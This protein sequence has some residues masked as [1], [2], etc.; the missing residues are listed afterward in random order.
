MTGRQ[1]GTSVVEVIVAMTLV[2]VIV[3]ALGGLT[4]TTARQMV[5]NTDVTT[6]QAASL[7]AVNRFTTI[8]FA[9]LGTA[10]GCDTVGSVNNGFQRCVTVATRGNS[11]A[12]EVRTMALQRFRVAGSTVHLTRVA[13]PAAN[14]LCLQC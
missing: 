12:V 1:Q 6:L 2:S 9:M 7:Q 3:T 8:P 11:A 5:T 4:F 14:P 10:A 13:P